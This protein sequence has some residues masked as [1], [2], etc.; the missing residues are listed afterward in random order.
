MNSEH[1]CE[2]FLEMTMMENVDGGEMI[3]FHRCKFVSAP[4]TIPYEDIPTV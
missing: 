3:I 4:D 2:Q 1:G